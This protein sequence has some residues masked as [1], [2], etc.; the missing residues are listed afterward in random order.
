MNAR[1]CLHAI[2][3]RAR[4][5]WIALSLLLVSGLAG[6]GDFCGTDCVLSEN[7]DD[8]TDGGGIVV[9][10]LP[11]GWVN[12]SGENSGASCVF[13]GFADPCFDWWVSS[14]VPEFAGS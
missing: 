5:V 9:G 6:A 7:F 2:P 10:A 1:R 11:P 13:D 14:G 12:V 3:D 8:A 4:S